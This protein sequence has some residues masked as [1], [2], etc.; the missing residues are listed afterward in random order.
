V[1]FFDENLPA[2]VAKALTS[3]GTCEATHQIDWLPKGAHDEQ[4]FGFLAGHP[5][6]VLV[7]QDKR[8][9]RK[10]QQ[11]QALLEAGVAAF[12]L[13]GRAEKSVE[14]LAVFF[15]RHMP[16]MIEYA[17]RTARPYV[18]GISDRG[19]FERLDVKAGK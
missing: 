1:F 19:V 5:G 11:V 18:F 17:R 3:L 16:R 4:I 10:P 9:S 13:T 14:D 8:I 6:W 7:T 15:I 12:I 2:S